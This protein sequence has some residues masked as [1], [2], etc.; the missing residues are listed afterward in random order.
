MKTP[1]CLLRRA[2]PQNTLVEITYLYV[3]YMGDKDLN[4]RR[5]AAHSLSNLGR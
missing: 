3:E 2:V 5:R 1:P 4:L